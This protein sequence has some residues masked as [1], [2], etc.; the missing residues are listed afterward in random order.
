MMF[1]ETMQQ[2]RNLSL[3]KVYLT[4]KRNIKIQVPCANTLIVKRDLVVAN[5]YN[6][7]S[8]SDDKMRLLYESVVD[9]GFAFPVVT[10]C[11]PDLELFVVVDG[12]HRYLITGEKWLALDY[13]PLVVLD[14]DI[15]Q[16]MVAT[17]QFNKAR[18]VHE[19][20][21]DADLIRSL[22]EQ[23]MAEEDIVQHLGIDL[24]TVYRYKQLTGIAALFQNSTY[25]MSW[26]IVETEGEVENE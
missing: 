21:L 8:V 16:R 18:G 9:N 10:I 7:N 19:V 1:I 14:H 23:G 4:G 12:F 11:D 5:N 13:V 20:D 26:N 3:S 25:S 6:P 2:Y 22:I 24:D 15:K 17:W